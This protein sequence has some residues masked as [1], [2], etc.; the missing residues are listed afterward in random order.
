MLSVDCK[1]KQDT[2][3]DLLEWLKSK[4]M[5]TAD[6]CKNVGTAETFLHCRWKCKMVQP[7]WKTIWQFL[8]KLNI[9]APYDPEISG[10]KYL[11]KWVENLC[12]HKNCT[13]IFIAA[14]NL[15]ATKMSFNRWIVWHIHIMEYNAAIK[16]NVLSSHENPRRN[17]KC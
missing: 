7:F 3:A 4:A 12:P 1:L 5:A 16:R 13:W 15:E 2:T 11:S 10:S 6:A 9:S 14:L 8:T 17:L